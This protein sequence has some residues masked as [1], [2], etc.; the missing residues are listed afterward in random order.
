MSCVEMVRLR[1]NQFHYHN[2]DRS[3]APLKYNHALDKQKM[4]V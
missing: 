3:C 2:K 4:L 1:D